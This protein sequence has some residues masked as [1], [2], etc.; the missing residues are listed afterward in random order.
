MEGLRADIGHLLHIFSGLP[1]LHSTSSAVS[2]ALGSRVI[3]FPGSAPSSALTNL[4]T[5]GVLFVIGADCFTAVTEV[6][7]P[8]S[9][10]V[11]MGLV[12]TYGR[13]G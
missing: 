3:G 8:S 1:H 11:K 10:K 6:S 5:I 4:H 7:L 2:P 12:V 9:G 13:S